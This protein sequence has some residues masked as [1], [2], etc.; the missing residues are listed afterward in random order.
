MSALLHKLLEF[1][2]PLSYDQMKHIRMDLLKH[3]KDKTDDGV[4][5]ET[6]FA[7]YIKQLQKLKEEMSSAMKDTKVL[8]NSDYWT[9]EGKFSA[10][11]F[12]QKDF[13]ELKK[14]Y[15]ANR[16]KH[17]DKITPTQPVGIITMS[18]ILMSDK[19]V[20]DMLGS[21]GWMTIQQKILFRSLLSTYYTYQE[22]LWPV[23][24]NMDYVFMSAQK[25][26]QSRLKWLKAQFDPVIVVQ[27]LLKAL[28]AGSGTFVLKMLQQINADN[29]NKI[30]DSISVSELTADLFAN[31]PG[32]SHREYEFIKENLHFKDKLVTR[33]M[34]D[35]KLGSA[36]I[37]EAHASL[38]VEEITSANG[39]K[40]TKLT[41]VIV[42]FIKPFYAFY[43]LCEC[44]LFLSVVW[45]SI[46]D[47]A[48][49][50][51]NAE[52]VTDRNVIKK[53]VRQCRQFLMFLMI[54]FIKEFDYQQEFVNTQVGYE[55]VFNAR[56]HSNVRSIRAIEVVISPF[57]AIVLSKAPGRPVKS[58]LEVWRGGGHSEQLKR[59]YTSVSDV[60]SRWFVNTLFGRGGYSVRDENSPNNPR[61]Q[62]GFFHADLHP[63]NLLYDDKTGLIYVI[64][65]GSCG[66][67]M[68]SDQENMI[69]AMLTAARFR[70]R[71]KNRTSEFQT[72]NRLNDIFPVLGQASTEQSGSLVRLSLENVQQ[73]MGSSPDWKDE[74]Q[75][76]SK[77][78]SQLLALLFRLNPEWTNRYVASTD[79]QSSFSEMFGKDKPLRELILRELR[80]FKREIDDKNMEICGDF[81]GHLRTLCGV[82]QNLAEQDPQKL[83]QSIIQ[84]SYNLW[85]ADAFLRF[86]KYATNIGSCT[87]SSILLFGRAVAYLGDLIM[88][89]TNV[90]NNSKDCP[91]WE[92]AGVIGKTLAHDRKL[93]ALSM[94]S[95][96]WDINKNPYAWV[97]DED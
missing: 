38:A 22:R 27:Q 42:K 11:I 60:C 7:L 31:V 95:T 49:A 76:S 88:S 97:A 80:K 55:K 48:T 52:G 43:F 23:H 45:K 20:E 83:Y 4:P 66:L 50:A 9:Q 61:Q 96:L 65:Y 93:F 57:P 5:T 28:L 41:E 39:Q 34:S 32:L 25:Q 6:G 77:D 62:G 19:S 16:R 24:V 85:F 3:M 54:E 37:A 84:D 17:L 59:L 63:G 44:D 8:D 81:V 29:Q 82:N 53:Y 1:T 72:L 94:A 64:D 47:Y 33:M 12:W 56:N 21:A 86:V 18:N 87:H 69:K 30:G 35:E 92:V 36:S 67:L 89:V 13:P 70:Q 91:I 10:D 51:M 40:E 79:L 14:I 46:A 74:F 75:D 71:K 90:C 73:L 15:D 26:V 58:W 68:P 2:S 78:G